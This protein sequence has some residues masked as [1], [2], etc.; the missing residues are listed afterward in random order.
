MGRPFVEENERRVIFM[1][2]MYKCSGREDPNHAMHSLYTGFVLGDVMNAFYM[3]YSIA[4]H[5][6]YQIV[7]IHESD[8]HR[9][10]FQKSIALIIE[11]QNVCFDQ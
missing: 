2:H 9:E 7:L 5:F 4:N 10:R 11:F 6:V 8:V 1:K 3:A